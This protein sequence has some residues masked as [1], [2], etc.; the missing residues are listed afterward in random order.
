MTKTK[1]TSIV[2]IVIYILLLSYFIIM[3][4]EDSKKSQETSG[5]VEEIVTEVIDTVTPSDYQVSEETVS[6]I[7]RKV[8][9]HF[10]YNV[11]MGIVLLLAI[12]FFLYLKIDLSDFGKGMIIIFAITLALSF[13]MAIFSELIQ[14]IPSGRS[15][16]IK[17]MAIDF[18]G[19][20][21]GAAISLV[22]CL[23]YLKT[24]NKKRD[25]V[26]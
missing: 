4:L 21:L 1:I 24:K 5:K 6:V 16:E 17:D 3:G 25:E 20:A 7:T 8:I 2:F 15:C 18:S 12:F 26:K 14:L 10:G 23:V 13:V 11:L 22:G 9:G 19:G